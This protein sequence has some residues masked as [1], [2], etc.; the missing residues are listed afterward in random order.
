MPKI[1]NLNPTFPFNF[2]INRSK[3]KSLV[4]YVKS[5]KVEVRAPRYAS[6]KWIHEFV[7]DKKEWIL[8]ELARQ[9]RHLRQRLVVADGREVSFLGKPRTIV[10]LVTQHQEVKA[11]RDFLFIYTRKNTQQHLEKLFYAWLKDKAREYMTTETMK[12]A[13][14]LGVEQKLKDVVFR[15]TKSKWGH[16]CQDG[17]IQYN[18]LAMMAPREVVRYLIV[19]ECSHLRHMNHSSRFWKT[20]ENVC[21]NYREHRNWLAENGHRF[22]SRME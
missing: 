6:S 1:C 11:T 13:R 20:V 22:W 21:P 3:R 19:H 12:V 2:E 10:A 14:Q 16:C 7:F 8:G 18:W 15:K 5:G 4:I 9:K 17:T